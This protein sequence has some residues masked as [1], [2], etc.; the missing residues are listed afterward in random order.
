V[1]A[2]WKDV[3]TAEENILLIHHS[4]VHFINNLRDGE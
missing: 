3:V 2:V 1:S 4:I